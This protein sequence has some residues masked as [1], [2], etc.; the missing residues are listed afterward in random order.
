[1]VLMGVQWGVQCFKGSTMDI[2]RKLNTEY[3]YEVF[4]TNLHQMTIL[5]L[6]NQIV[7]YSAC[8]ILTCLI[9]RMMYSNWP[10]SP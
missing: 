7:F 9:V 4:I 5:K 3:T 8:I 2:P 10:L 6:W 1:M